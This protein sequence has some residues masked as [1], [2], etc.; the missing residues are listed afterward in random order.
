MA[1]RINISGRILSQPQAETGSLGEAL[2]AKLN[3]D[4]SFELKAVK[5]VPEHIQRRA[6]AARAEREDSEEPIL[7]APEDYAYTDGTH[8]VYRDVEYP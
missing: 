8:T 2:K 4:L 1:D 3:R 6:D 5:E 7:D